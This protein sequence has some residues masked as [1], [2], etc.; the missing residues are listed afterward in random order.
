MDDLREVIKLAQAEGRGTISDVIRDLVHEALAYRR[1][2]AMGRDAAEE[3]LRR[4]DRRDE[5]APAAAKLPAQPRPERRSR[6]KTDRRARREE[7]PEHGKD[8]RRTD[9]ITKLKGSGI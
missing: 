2:R 4:D 7:P 6:S 3:P 1:L 8:C 9:A 5:D